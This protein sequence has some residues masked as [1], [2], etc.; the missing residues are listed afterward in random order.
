MSTVLF[1][2][3]LHYAMGYQVDHL[4]F[5]HAPLI[6]HV[7]PMCILAAQDRAVTLLFK[8]HAQLVEGS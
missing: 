6:Q 5:V 8:L 4:L 3:L 7:L 1:A 2:V